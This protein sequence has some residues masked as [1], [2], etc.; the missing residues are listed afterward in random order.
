MKITLRRTDRARL[1]PQPDQQAATTQVE[2]EA[3]VF[4]AT[5][6]QLIWWRFRRHTLAM[7]SAVVITLIYLT[8]LLVEF[9][10]PFSPDVTN[11]K[12][13]YAPPQTLHFYDPATRTVAPYVYGIKSTI[14]STAN[15]RIFSTDFKKKIPIRLFAKSEPY[16]LMGFILID[17]KLLAPVDKTQPMFLLGADRLGR[18]LLS[19][20][21]YG[22]RISMSIGFIG[23]VLSLFLGVLLGGISGYYG[24]IMDTIIQRVIEFLRSIPTIPLWMGLAA[25][26]PMNWPPLKVYFGITV[27]LSL[28]GWTGLA[29]VVRSRF[30]AMRSEEFVLAAELDGA[31]E[32]RIIFRYMM[33]SFLSHIIASTT[34][35]IP[36]MI[37]SETSLSFLGLGLRPPIISWG[38]LLKDAQSVRS[39]LTAP[40]QLWP[41]AAV[42]IAVLALNFLGDGLRDASDPY[43]R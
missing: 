14:D 9:L 30:L 38:V 26:L 16:K 43:S 19:R 21:I 5:Q 13:L 10:A 34:L 25:A 27:I 11:S 24:G 37:L 42:I 31:S 22:T 28:I 20:I 35:A 32:M 15:R 1:K 33:P 8:A 39:V 12:Y 40:W 4:V 17:R 41:A 18:D 29:R 6:W 2:K 3:K 36:A 23:V 7:V